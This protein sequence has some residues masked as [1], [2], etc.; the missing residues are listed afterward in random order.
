[1]ADTE[2]LKALSS[3]DNDLAQRDFRQADLS[4]TN[5]SDRDFS[6][7][8][9]Q[10]ANFSQSILSRSKFSRSSTMGFVARSAKFDAI[11]GT[12][13][14]WF[15]VDFTDADLA[16]ANFERSHFT[17]MNFTRAD[18]RQ[19]NFQH[20]HIDES[21][22]FDDA[23]TDEGT[24][25]DNATIIRSLA[26]QKAFRFYKVERG[27]LVRLPPGEAP[28]STGDDGKADIIAAANAVERAVGAALAVEYADLATSPGLGHNNPPPD[29]A[30]SK[31]EVDEVLLATRSIKHEIS[32]ENVD[33]EKI[34]ASLAIVQ[35]AGKSIG[36]WSLD[37]ANVFATEFAKSLGKEAATVKFWVAL[38]LFAS[39]EMTKLATLI[40]AHFPS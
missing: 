1:M 36:N 40:V 6:G 4:N 17:R 28:F 2:D 16:G 20:C 13:T 32:A 7:A 33:P 35:K 38:W 19:A 31:E 34:K 23:Q 18:L 29:Q 39:G 15:G 11:D 9:L 26:R 5:L 25:F 21:C 12:A 8:L 22:V 10:E 37:K 30:L 14:S 24:L 27:I 3:G